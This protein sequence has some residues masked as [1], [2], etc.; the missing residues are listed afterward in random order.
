MGGGP[1]KEHLLIA[2]WDPEP[3]HFTS[4]IKRRFPYIDIN[5][6]QIPPPTSASWKQN[7]ADSANAVPAGESLELE[8]PVLLFNYLPG[9]F[10]DGAVRIWERLVAICCSLILALHGA[11]KARSVWSPAESQAGWSD[12]KS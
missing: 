1:D 3:V 12:Q 4:E 6:V 9:G 7:I 8:F 5:Y 2:L 10:C 11:Q